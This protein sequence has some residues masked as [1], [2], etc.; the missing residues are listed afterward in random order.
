MCTKLIDFDKSS[1]MLASDPHG[2]RQNSSE[3]NTE[4]KPESVPSV[5]GETINQDK[6]SM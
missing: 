1:N 6:R 5:P 2:F 3:F 4:A